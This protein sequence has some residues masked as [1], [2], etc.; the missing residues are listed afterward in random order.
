MPGKRILI[1]S[2]SPLKSDPRVYRQIIFLKDDYELIAAGFSDPEIDGVQFTAIEQKHS[3]LIKR[4]GTVLKLKTGRYEDFYWSM[5][6][7]KSAWFRLKSIR[8]DLIIA[9]ELS[10]LPLA[11]ELSKASKAKVFLDAHE[12]TP[13]EF[14]NNPIWRFIFKEFWEYICFKYLPH[15]SVMTSVCGGI[16]EEYSR[17][18]GVKCEVMNNA[19]FF[20]NQEVSEVV[21]GHIRL[22]H[23]GG[24]HRSRKLENM[25]SLIDHLDERFFLDFVLVPDNDLGYFTELQKKASTKE[26]I[27]FRD[28]VPMTEIPCRLNEYDMGIYFL[29]PKGFNNKLALPNKFFEFIQARLGICIWPGPEMARIVETHGLGIVS[30]GFS[31]ESAAAQLNALTTEDVVRFKQ[32]SDLAAGVYCAE[33]NQDKLV[34]IV[35]ELIGS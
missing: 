21:G 7:V 13:R 32:N 8:C 20:V 25:I 17:L 10:S 34:G 12:F 1:L 22:V 29:D 6:S 18:Y 27:I 19:P 28:P 4:L 9:N 24:I 11:L 5:H 23:H 33:K 3:S 35:D 15:I 26:R 2:F 31:V 14:D 30:D 16:A